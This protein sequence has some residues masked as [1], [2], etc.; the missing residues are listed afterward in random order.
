VNRLDCKLILL[1]FPKHTSNLKIT[2]NNKILLRME[3]GRN[4][5]IKN[6]SESVT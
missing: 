4:T 6:E 2:H 3:N 5:N 1:L